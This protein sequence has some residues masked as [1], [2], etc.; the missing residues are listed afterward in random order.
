VAPIQNTLE[1]SKQ[2]AAFIRECTTPDAASAL[3]FAELPFIVF[4]CGLRALPCG[5]FDLV[6]QQSNRK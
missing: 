2:N 4:I 5:S 6:T 3:H 1:L